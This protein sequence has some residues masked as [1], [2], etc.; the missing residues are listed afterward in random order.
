MLDELCV[1]WRKGRV[2]ERWQTR[3]W[4]CPVMLRWFPVDVSCVAFI[5]YSV[6]V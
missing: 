3:K 5:C 2:V 1:C 6:G 4:V